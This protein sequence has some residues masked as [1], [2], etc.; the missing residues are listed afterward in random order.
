[1]ASQVALSIQLPFAVVPLVWFTSRK[2][3][4]RVDVRE[5]RKR[6]LYDNEE[7]IETGDDNGKIRSNS[8]ISLESQNQNQNSPSINNDDDKY[9]MD[10]SNSYILSGI[11]CVVS[12]IIISLDLYLVIDVI[13]S[14]ISGTSNED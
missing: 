9:F 12:L 7:D 10:F 4:M 13:R 14:A 5:L 1:V 2:K 3:Y 8:V 11:A 6:E